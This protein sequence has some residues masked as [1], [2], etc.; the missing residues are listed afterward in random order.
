VTLA[1]VVVQAQQM[2]H[3]EGWGHRFCLKYVPPRGDDISEMGEMENGIP[4]S[5]R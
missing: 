2:D 1:E 5:V 4:V 3:N